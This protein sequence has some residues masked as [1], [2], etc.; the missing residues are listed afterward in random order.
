MFVGLI[1]DIGK[2]Y[3]L[4]RVEEHPEL[5]ASTEALVEIVDGWHTAIGRAILENWKF[6]EHVLDAVDNH[7]N[8]E[9]KRFGEPDLADVLIVANLF[10]NIQNG[11]GAAE[12]G[13]FDQVASCQRMGIDDQAYRDVMSESQEEIAELMH[14]LSG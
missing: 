12:E 3:I 14:A 2:L 6:P 5:F 10:S 11:P 7:D 9:L 13:R 8:E 1:H 4:T